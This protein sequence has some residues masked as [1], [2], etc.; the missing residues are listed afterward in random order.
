MK[1]LTCKIQKQADD[2]TAMHEGVSSLELMEQAAARMTEV[3]ADRWDRSHRMVIFAG[4]GNNGGDAVAVARMLHERGYRVEVYLFNTS[5]NIAENTRINIQR[6]QEAGCTAYT[7]I[8]NSFKSPVLVEED[9]V[10]DGLFGIGLT[11]GLEGGFAAVVQFINQSPASVVALDIPSGLMGE[12]NSLNKRINII[13]ADL[14][15]TVHRPKLAFLFSENEEFVGEWVVLDAG[16]SEAFTQEATSPYYITEREEVASLVRTRKRF[17][18]KG[19]FGHALLIAG[20]K[21]MGGCS[22]L[23]ARA[24]LR[25]G[26]GLLTVHAPHY[27][28][29]ILQTSVPEAMV[30]MDADERIFTFPVDAD[31]YDAV[32]MGPGLGTDP[33]TASALIRQIQQCYN[34]PVVLDADA[35]NIFSTHR[36]DLRHIPPGSVLTPHIGELERLVGN[37]SNTYERLMKAKD[38]AEELRSYVVLKGAWTA[39]VTPEGEC[40]FNTSGNPGMAVGGSGDV[41]TGILT[42][43]LAQGY[44]S[45]DACRLGVY[46]HGLAGDIAAHRK[47][48]IAMTA[49]D[50]VEALPEAWLSLT[51]KNNLV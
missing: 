38:L 32:G 17:A 31:A 36:A 9:V 7:E 21:G 19:E 23:A 46:L 44:H 33:V 1:I 12:D 20:S 51:E 27:N 39:V 30:S 48:Q 50:I 26:V 5:G 37:C 16:I 49:G 24:A 45:F 28:T 35:L 4:A 18:H 41:L 14:T 10:I 25:A 8:T 2:Y 29:V 34:M 43:L 11:R 6:L 13:R 40:H 15:L 22:V 47:G 42:S 3:I